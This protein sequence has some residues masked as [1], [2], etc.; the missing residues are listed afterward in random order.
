MENLQVRN[1]QDWFVN[2]N[3]TGD[4]PYKSGPGAYEL[5]QYAP[6]QSWNIGKVPFGSNSMFKRNAG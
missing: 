2:K 5:Q 4:Q 6:K 1:T 3:F